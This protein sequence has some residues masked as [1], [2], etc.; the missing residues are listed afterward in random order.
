MTLFVQS[1]PRI[2]SLADFG[3]VPVP[4]GS[5]AVYSKGTDGREWVRKPEL[6]TGVEAILAESIGYLLGRHLGVPI[7]DAAVHVLPD[8]MAWLSERIPSVVHWD[9]SRRDRVINWD[10]MGSM[11]TL[12]AIIF[13]EDRHGGNILL[14]PSPDDLHL[15]AW[16]IDVGD[17]LVGQPSD[18]IAKKLV[19]PDPKRN[20]AT[21]LPVDLLRDRAVAAA[22]VARSIDGTLLRE[23]VHE[24]CDL[25]GESDRDSLVE[26][27]E[28]RCQSAPAIVLRYLDLLGERG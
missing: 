11:A 21:G 10:E 14:Q 2:T 18:F 17:A 25:A 24:G 6:T 12:D 28:A 26:A 15:K 20:H 13:N 4:N 27:L 22:E 1:I 3:P 23:W 7:P 9:D 16:A 19:A 5:N 8:G